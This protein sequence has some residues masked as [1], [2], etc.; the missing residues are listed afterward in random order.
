ML[1][2][3]KDPNITC[4]ACG[5]E[6]QDHPGVER[7]CKLAAALASHLRDILAYAQPPE[8]RRDFGKQEIY[9]ELLENCRRLVVEASNWKHRP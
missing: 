6:W 8:Y 1:D 7:T 2:T 4:Q 5:R 3:N 9:F